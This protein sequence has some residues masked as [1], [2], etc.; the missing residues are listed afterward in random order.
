MPIEKRWLL[1]GPEGDADW[2]KLKQ[3]PK[4][5]ELAALSDRRQL[6]LLWQHTVYGPRFPDLD[7]V[8]RKQRCW[9]Q[10]TAFRQTGQAVLGD[11][12]RYHPVDAAGRMD[13]GSFLSD[14]APNHHVWCSGKGRVSRVSLRQ[15][16]VFEATWHV[17][18]LTGDPLPLHRVA[19]H[20]RCTAFSNWPPSLSDD[21]RTQIHTLA[22]MLGPE[23]AVCGNYASVVDH[24][25]LTGQV[26]G[27]L[28]RDCNSR[29]DWC[30]HADGC[31]MAEYLNDPPAAFLEM[32]YRGHA[33]SPRSPRWQMRMTL[34]VDAIV[35][36][37]E[38]AHLRRYV[39]DE[40]V[41]I[42]ACNR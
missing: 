42:N 11:D 15:A 33:A 34:L 31:S 9:G 1:E 3:R 29:V 13:C 16:D 2:E 27:L 35:G 14:T 22:E 21:K 6:N 5:G 32:T 18:L 12:G 26:R 25:H 39:R 19:K 7:A 4:V 38:L 17:T 28:C 8:M 40:Q 20:E 30:P 36:Q 37:P 24:D 41:V 23:C 10:R